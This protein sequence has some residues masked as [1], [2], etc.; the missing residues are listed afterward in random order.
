LTF[1]CSIDFLSNTT[2]NEAQARRRMPKAAGIN[3]YKGESRC[4]PPNTTWSGGVYTMN[5]PKQ[6]PAIIPAKFHI[7]ATARLPKGNV[8]LAFT[9]KTYGTFYERKVQKGERKYI[10]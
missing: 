4:E 9:A 8:N 3:Q 10:R 2:L 5:M 6:A 1:R 7:L